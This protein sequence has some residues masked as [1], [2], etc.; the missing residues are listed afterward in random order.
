MTIRRSFSSGR[1]KVC[2]HY[3]AFDLGF[4]GLDRDGVGELNELDPN[5][6]ALAVQLAFEVLPAAGQYEYES[7]GV[8]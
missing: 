4:R 2:E 3:A 6:I 5:L 7:P 1:A 8:V